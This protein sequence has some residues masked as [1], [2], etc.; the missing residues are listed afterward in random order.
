MA[1][2]PIFRGIID[3]LVDLG[4]YDVI[5]PFLLVFT[6]VFAIMEKTR[7][8]GTEEVDGKE[9]TKKN[10][11]SMVAFVIAFLVVASKKLVETINEALANIVLLLLLIVMF[12]MLAGTLFKQGEQEIIKGPG[13]IAFM[14]IILI[15]IVLI[16]LHAI[17]TDDGGNWLETAWTWL[18]DNWSGNAV[19]SIILV[20][21]VAAMI[22]YLTKDKKP[23]K[24]KA[25][26]D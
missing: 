8:L 14:V 20:I 15:T 25:V 1:D 4:I 2:E 22:G 6:I 17:P 26:E 23:E 10:L 16:F 18:G 13:R 11:N 21:F 12:L 24:P 7:V 5:L 9:Y 3:F 19:G